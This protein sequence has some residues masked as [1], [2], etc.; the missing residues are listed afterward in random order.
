M[1]VD[2]ITAIGLEIYPTSVLK[3]LIRVFTLAKVL[4]Q[5]SK[6]NLRM[7]GVPYGNIRYRQDLH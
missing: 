7:Y 2:R 4:K 3:V 5:G 1:K 6:Y